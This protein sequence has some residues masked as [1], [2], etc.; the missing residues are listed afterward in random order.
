MG[1]WKERVA[2]VEMQKNE[3]IR[4]N[5]ESYVQLYNE[6]RSVQ[7]RVKLLDTLV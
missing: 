1:K 7:E 5:E 3:E 6:H 2:D 4:I